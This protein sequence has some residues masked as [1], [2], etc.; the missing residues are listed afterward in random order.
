M[1][2]RRPVP[3]QAVR[4]RRA[5]VHPRL[6]DRPTGY[7]L[8]DPR[9]PSSARGT[10]RRRQALIV[11]SSTMLQA[12]HN[13]RDLS[14]DLPTAG[15]GRPPR[16]MRR[17]VTERS[18]VPP[19]AGRR[20]VPGPT[21]PHGTRPRLAHLVGAPGS[22]VDVL[23]RQI[24]RW[25]GRRRTPPPVV[26]A[27][28]RNDG[29]KGER[30]LL[31]QSPSARRHQAQPRHGRSGRRHILRVPSAIGWR[32][33]VGGAEAIANGLPSPRQRLTVTVRHCLRSGTAFVIASGV[34]RYFG[35]VA[36]AIT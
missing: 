34:G 20:P 36:P 16:S 35:G 23:P 1:R 4:A 5:G 9:L 2:R 13:G 17:R 25:R 21:E 19:R 30:P 31:V 8:S 26:A 22:S 11:S 27:M 6:A 10:A 28:E 14:A 7:E 29:M 12:A 33:W 24:R 3:G 18:H 32:R 15:G